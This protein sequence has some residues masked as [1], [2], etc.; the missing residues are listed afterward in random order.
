MTK[1]RRPSHSVPAL[2]VLIA[3]LT[4]LFA[5]PGL[6]LG[7][8]EGAPV[9]GP[10]TIDWTRSASGQS[11]V[12]SIADPEGRI[13]R[14]VFGDLKARGDRVDLGG[15]SALAFSLFDA[16]GHPR[17]EGAYTWEL[18]TAPAG[19]GE[20]G[21]VVSGSFR[22]LGGTFVEPDRPETQGG[23]FQ[24][25]QTV[26]DDLIVNGS[27]CVGI[28]CVN[29][30]T[31]GLDNL[32]LK[33]DTL[34]FKFEDTSSASGFPT[35]DWQI[36]ANDF[37]SG[38][39][40]K[41]S[42]EDVS[43]VTVPFTIQGGAPSHSLYVGPTGKIGIRTSVP[44]ADLHV[45]SGNTP[46]LRLEQNVSSL[47]PAQTWDL[48][49]GVDRIFSIRDLSAAADGSR[50]P[51]RIQPGAPS[52]SVDVTATG[53][54][55]F[56]TP[57][58]AAQLHLFGTGAGTTAT[59]LLVENANTGAAA[60]RELYELR[61]HGDVAF[62]VDDTTDAERWSFGTF[63]HT[64]LIN[65]QANHPALEYTFGP[66]GNLTIGGTLTQNS[67]RETKTA[68]TVVDPA[69]ILQKV[70]GL[71]IAT[72][73]LK[74]D[75]ERVKHLGPMAQDFSAAFGLGEDDRHIAPADLASVSLAA[76]QA[77]YREVQEL[78]LENER[79][80]VELRALQAQVVGAER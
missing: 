64:F 20:P 29:G 15:Q 43:A 9:V 8:D 46:T 79:Q 63:N 31:F 1:N 5:A 21:R 36:T 6:V 49:G 34:R 19:K 27:L 51:L 11:G 22:I 73:Q 48:A 26:P 68:I 30:E 62:I 54:V 67:D 41:L 75:P 44:A 57:S 65:N 16:T 23:A 74:S 7:L 76:I 45:A 2:Y 38:G 47:N 60:P 77:L 4:A 58:P 17:P 66:T 56:G 28:P 25:D 18:V 37:A 50:Q 78:K 71:P 12:L 24:R 40:N 69:E 61:N 80:A 35:T 55:G 53:F 72:W 13:E 39:L 52:S 70:S 59:K 32:K 14:L 42:I 3:L 33:S 10:T